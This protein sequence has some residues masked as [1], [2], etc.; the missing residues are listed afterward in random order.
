VPCR[1]ARPDCD[2]DRFGDDFFV[3][4]A[5]D[6]ARIVVVVTD[7]TP[8]DRGA[9][10]VGATVDVAGVRSVVSGRTA[11]IKGASVVV[12]DTAASAVDVVGADDP[13]DGTIDEL[14]ADNEKLTDLG[15]STFP[16]TS[17]D[18]YSTT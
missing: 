12:G 11:G 5:D 18:Q 3:V 15:V 16:A 17:C 14:G 2:H 7:R 4:V 6:L 8:F 1:V 10:V 9:I 13:T